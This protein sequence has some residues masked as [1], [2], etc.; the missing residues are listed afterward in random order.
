MLARMTQIDYDRELALVAIDTDGD[1]ET[2]V[3]AARIINDPDGRQAEFAIMIAD[4]WQGK[5]LGALLLQKLI[6]IGRDRGLYTIWG[7]VL[8][9][10]RSMLRLGKK[11]GFSSAYDSDVEMYVLTI[12][13]S[14]AH[15]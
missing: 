8:K 3:G 5:G 2:M 6:A 14:S 1:R 15:P 10:N 9:E 11:V 4:N 7:Y 12:D 13:L